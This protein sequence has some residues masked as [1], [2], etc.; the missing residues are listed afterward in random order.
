MD[1]ATE[2]GATSVLCTLLGV[3]AHQHVIPSPIYNLWLSKLQE[4]LYQYQKTRKLAFP[5]Y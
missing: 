4:K 5:L 2:T 1:I 3:S